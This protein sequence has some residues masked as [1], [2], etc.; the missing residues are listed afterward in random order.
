MIRV[1]MITVRF[2]AGGCFLITFFGGISS[3]EGLEFVFFAA[4]TRK[5]LGGGGVSGGLIFGRDLLTT[6][7]G[8]TV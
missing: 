7:G 3:A 8:S 2:L 4:L 5:K 1:M 6:G